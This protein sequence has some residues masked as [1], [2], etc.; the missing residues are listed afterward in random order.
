MLIFKHRLD[1]LFHDAVECL[2]AA[3]EARDLYSSGH[4]RRVADMVVDLA[5]LVGL[6]GRELEMVHIAAHFDL[7]HQRT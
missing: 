6:K 7:G 2:V 4:S 3:L 1:N 5:R